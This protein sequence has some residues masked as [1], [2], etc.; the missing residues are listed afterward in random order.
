MP[1]HTDKNTNYGPPLVNQKYTPLNGPTFEADDRP[2]YTGLLN[3]RMAMLRA[4]GLIGAG[5]DL[6]VPDWPSVARAEA[7]SSPPLV[8]VSSGRA[9]WIR[10]GLDA[11]RDQLASLSIAAF[12]NVSDLRALRN[13]TG[14]KVSPP[15]YAPDRV[16]AGRNVY[17]VVN[18]AEYDYYQKKL[19][20]TRI[21]P[22]G[23]RF[24]KGVSAQRSLTMLGFGA[25]RF[26]ALEFCKTLR[27][28]ARER[29]GAAPWDA[30][31]MIDDNVVALTSFP[32]FAAVE[33][34]LGNNVCAGFHGGTQALS[35]ARNKGW[36]DGEWNAGRRGQEDR[37]PA[38]ERLGIIQQAALWNIAYCDDRRLNFGPPFITSAEDLSII[39]YFN[40]EGIPYQFYNGIGVRKEIPESDTTGGLAK[41]HSGRQSLTRWIA[42][43]ESADFTPPGG[44]PPPPIRVQPRNPDDGGEQ[45]LSTFITTRV[46]PKASAEISAKANNLDTQ[47]QAKSQAVEQLTS[48]ALNGGLVDAAATTATFYL[49]GTGQQTVQLRNRPSRDRS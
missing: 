48:G 27:L 30:A 34:A 12:D 41:V 37:L 13:Q 36:A 17:M 31:W 33:A 47:A 21:T 3:N 23:W 19:K 18:I 32:G 43:A 6:T 1:V 4:L 28:Q 8:V 7:G 25:T 39:N 26:A 46:L 42:A 44:S 29:A 22:V 20:D 9:T 10:S 35:Q 49:N 11:G 38:A 45:T 15:W 24:T 14:A 2:L 40:H 5:L 16:G